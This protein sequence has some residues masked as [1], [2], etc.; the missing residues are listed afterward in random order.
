ML[1]QPYLLSAAL[2]TPRLLCAPQGLVAWESPKLMSVTPKR[3]ILM[4]QGGS[5][6]SLFPLNCKDME[7]QSMTHPGSPSWKVAGREFKPGP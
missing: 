5:T 7:A 3:H 4:A 6:P 2:G 1:A